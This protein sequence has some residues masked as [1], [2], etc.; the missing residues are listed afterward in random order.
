MKINELLLEDFCGF[1]KARFELGDFNCLIGPNGIGKT[2]ILEAIVL[3]CS[4]LDFGGAFEEEAAEA[5]ED[6]WVPSVSAQA[7]L[8][9]FLRRNIRNIDEEG[10]AK[11]FR[12]S[13]E[14]EHDGKKR[15]I[16]LTSKGFEKNDILEEPWWWHGLCYFAKFDQDMVNFQLPMDL[17]PNFAEGWEG[18]TG[19]AVEPDIYRV[20][21]SKRED[22]IAAMLDRDGESEEEGKEF[23]CGFYM[24]K[25]GDRIHSRK[26]SAGERKIAKALSQIVALP[27]ERLPHIVLVDNIEIHVARERRLGVVEA[28]KRLF[29][30][31][32]L[33]STTHS[34]EI[35]DNYEPREHLIDVESVRMAGVTQ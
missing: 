34:G 29:A 9:G 21:T 7:R 3:L 27:P 33:I 35:I 6:D 8:E 24:T 5:G 16:V 4:S 31:R 22:S 30:G 2:T 13:C 25:F 1:R 23:A 17:W 18:I 32:Q 20:E 19:I 10:E 12:L 15:E 14:A 11:G 28:V 26:A